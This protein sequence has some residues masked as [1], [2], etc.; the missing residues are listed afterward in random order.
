MIERIGEFLMNTP[1]WD[2]S[3]IAVLVVVGAFVGFVN[4]V[5]GM[6][7]VISYG[8]FM[9]MGM[10]INVAN[11]TSRVGVLLQFSTNSVIYRREG[12]LDMGLATRVGIPVALGAFFGAEMASLLPPKVMEIATGIILPIIVVLLLQFK[13]N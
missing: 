6:A 11:A 4:T 12:L 8:L 2:P 10:P 7:T 13:Q 1:W 9:A 5:A 3:I